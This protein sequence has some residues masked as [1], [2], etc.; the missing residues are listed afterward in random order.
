MDDF[1]YAIRLFCPS[2]ELPKL[3]SLLPHLANRRWKIIAIYF[4][5]SLVL[6]LPWL[7][8][9]KEDEELYKL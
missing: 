1:I 4:D 6:G 2:Q 5:V 3:P 8:R 9:D 7:Q